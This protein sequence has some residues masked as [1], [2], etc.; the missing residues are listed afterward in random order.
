MFEG[1]NS[2]N[3]AIVDNSYIICSMSDYLLITQPSSM[4]HWVRQRE[5]L[6]YTQY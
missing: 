2:Y 5:M 3:H 4:P 6:M 1:G